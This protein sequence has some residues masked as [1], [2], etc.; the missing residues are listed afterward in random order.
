MNY[1]FGNK[2]PSFFVLPSLQPT[3]A[4]QTKWQ[5]P[6]LQHLID[7]YLDRH[8]KKGKKAEKDIEEILRKNARPL[9]HKPLSAITSDDAE[10]LH[11]DIGRRAKIIAN[12]TIQYLRAAWNK[13][14]IWN[15]CYGR[16]PFAGI[17]RFPERARNRILSADEMNRLFFVLDNSR[18]RDLRDFV[19]LAL[20]TGVR[21]AKILSMRWQDVNVPEHKWRTQ[22]NKNGEDQ[23]IPLGMRELDI[24]LSR[25]RISQWVFPSKVRRGA[26]IICIKEAWKGLTRKAKIDDLNIHDLRR[27]LASAMLEANVNVKIVQSAM[28]HKTLDTTLRVYGHTSKKAELEARQ[29][30]QDQWL[31]QDK[32]AS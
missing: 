31:G 5:E 32:K 7:A 20:F 30:V 1:Q 18:N 11:Q 8:I 21:K 3:P 16:N 19:Y 25:P 27:S 10:T 14:V 22:E 17:T 12:R 28:H 6:T 23:I 29:L 2:A 15:M 4:A 24:I 9:M 13:G 26:P